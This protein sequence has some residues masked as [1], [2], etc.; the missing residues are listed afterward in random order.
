VTPRRLDRI[1]TAY[2]I[3]DPAGAYP[4]FDAAGSRLFPG[5]WNTRRSPMIYASRHYSTAVLEKLA[6]GSGDLP[7][8]QHFV[9]IT[10]DAGVSYEVFSEAHNPGWDSP[11]ATPAK[12]FGEAWLLAARTAVLLVPSYVA[13][14][15]QNVLINPAHPDF[16]RIRPGL[17]TPV[18][19][20]ERL[21]G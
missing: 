19:W 10:I 20:D 6:T 21:F 15:E 5:R 8:N 11:A 2:R 18:W 16:P 9:E 17:A 14:M 13:R 3:G 12:A 7:A 1:L 4:I